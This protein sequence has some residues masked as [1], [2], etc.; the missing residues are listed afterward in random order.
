LQQQAG[1]LADAQ[2]TLS[3]SR[4]DWPAVMAV[5]GTYDQNH[6]ALTSVIQTEENLLISGVADH[7]TA[8]MTYIG[9]LQ[10]SGILDRVSI[11]SITVNAVL[12]TATPAPEGTSASVLMPLEFTIQ[13]SI[14]ESPVS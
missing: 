7:E 10:L 14:K 12:E 6:M 11:L 3:A 8:V 1:T 2:V 9:A 4:L 5:I 13:V